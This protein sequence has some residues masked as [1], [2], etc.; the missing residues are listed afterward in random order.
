MQLYI[1][2]TVKPVL[3][4]S[5]AEVNKLQQIRRPLTLYPIV[6]QPL[7]ALLATALFLMPRNIL[8]FTGQ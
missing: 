2:T 8:E 1:S 5:L 4:P 3:R 7:F 6:L